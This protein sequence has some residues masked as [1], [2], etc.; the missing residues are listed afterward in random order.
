MCIEAIERQHQQR[1]RQ[2]HH[3]KII[4][5]RR[6]Q[7]RHQQIASG[8]HHPPS[9]VLETP[10]PQ[11]IGRHR[12]QRHPGHL[13]DLQG[14][15]A[16]DDPIEGH[17]GQ[18]ERLE[19]DAPAGGVAQA[20]AIADGIADGFVPDMA[21]RGIPEDLIHDAQVFGVGAQG[22]MELID[23]A[24]E[25]GEEGQHRQEGDAQADRAQGATRHGRQWR[26]AGKEEARTAGQHAPPVGQRTS[27][28]GVCRGIM[29]EHIR[30]HTPRAQ[31]VHPHQP[32]DLAF[33][34]I[35]PCHF[36]LRNC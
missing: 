29:L 3:V 30:R 14:V 19:V 32:L 5:H 7:H 22:L 35:P 15:R 13:D 17:E 21:V 1:R 10:A 27:P 33:E 31:G 9:D 36:C 8:E 4:D 28:R 20:I 23:I 26:Q 34:M 11:P 6:P 16:R 18:H 24:K 2:R 25:D 12:A